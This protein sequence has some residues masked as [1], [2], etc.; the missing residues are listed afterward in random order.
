MSTARHF[1][2]HSRSNHHFQNHSFH[3]DKQLAA[4]CYAFH[5][6]P[7]YG[8]VDS[9]PSSDIYT[10]TRVAL[11]DGNQLKYYR[12]SRLEDEAKQTDYISNGIGYHET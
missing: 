10:E 9:V 5:E 1:R 8:Y 11:G 2:P 7:S 6:Y 3:S 4:I 12:T